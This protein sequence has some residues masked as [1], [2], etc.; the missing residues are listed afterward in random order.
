MVARKLEPLPDEDPV[1]A[2]FRNAPLAD[3]PETE[4]ERAADLEAIADY[5][6]GLGRRYSSADIHADVEALQRDNAAE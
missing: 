1:L 6:L 3:E 2:A 5:Q 4:E